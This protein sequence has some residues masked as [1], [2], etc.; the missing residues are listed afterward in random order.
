MGNV[1]LKTKKSKKSIEKIFEIIFIV[2]SLIST[3]AI[4]VITLY[5]IISGGP[6]IAEIGIFEFI[7]GKIWNP[8]AD[9]PQF[10]ILPMILSTLFATT[11]SIIIGVPIGILGGVF[12]AFISPKRLRPFFRTAVE[13]LAGIPS[14][15]YGLIG[16]LIIAP[17]VAKIFNLP[18]GSNLFSAIIILS[19]MILPTIVMITDSSLSAISPSLKEASLGLGATDIQTIFKVLIPAAKSGIISG[20]VLGI[21]RA[22]GETMAVIMVAGNVVNLPKLFE[23]VRLMTIGIVLE[24]SY[25]TEFHRAA[26]FGIG[27]ILFIFIMILNIFLTTFLKKA[28]KKY[29]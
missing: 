7:F 29:D 28:G 16:L 14:V 4:V 27:L 25:A 10:G 1:L 11:G 9:D 13:L 8:A 15:I 24:M 3:A 19:I 17:T 23:S 6:A 26:L 2:C 5:M 12:L 21:G 22:I 20:I 18:I